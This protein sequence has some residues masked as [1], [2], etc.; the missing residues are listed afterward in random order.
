MQEMKGMLWEGGSKEEGIIRTVSALMSRFFTFSH[1]FTF[2]GSNPLLCAYLQ[3][4]SLQFATFFQ[5][6]FIRLL[7]R[8]IFLA[9]IP[10]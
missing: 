4:K 3:N 10:F 5:N 1:S 2:K 9:G 6:P 7:F 8:I